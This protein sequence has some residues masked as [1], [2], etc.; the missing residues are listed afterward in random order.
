MPQRIRFF[1]YDALCVLVFV[2]IGTRNHDTDTGIQGVLFVAAPFWIALFL[3]YVTP[4][5][6]S[7]FKPLPHPYLVVGY[8]LVMG[9]VLRN[10]VFSR[11]T[12]TAFVIVAAVFLAASMLGWRKVHDRLRPPAGNA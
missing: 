4:L 1:L 2:V 10:V 9:M 11:G 12:A 8:T 7:G 5:L 3:A 6:Q